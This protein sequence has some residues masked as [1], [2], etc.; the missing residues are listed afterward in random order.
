[1]G[2][3]PLI[4]VKIGEKISRRNDYKAVPGLG[5]EAWLKW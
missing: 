2:K 3:C 1:L 5:L 4:D